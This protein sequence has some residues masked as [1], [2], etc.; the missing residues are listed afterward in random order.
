MR[1][2]GGH[3]TVKYLLITWAGTDLIKGCD[4]HL[5]IEMKYIF[6]KFLKYVTGSSL[7]DTVKN[8]NTKAVA[9]LEKSLT[10][11]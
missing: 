1:N 2:L 7:V 8:E 4:C 11:F 9:D 5:F 3:S 10:G 6:V